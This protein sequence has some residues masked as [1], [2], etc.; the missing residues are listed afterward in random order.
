MYG[1]DILYQATNPCK[2]LASWKTEPWAR[3]AVLKL[4]PESF[5]FFLVLVQLRKIFSISHNRRSFQAV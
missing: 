3:F 2:D 4:F 5:K 1:S